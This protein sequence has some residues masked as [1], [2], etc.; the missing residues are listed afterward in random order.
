MELSPETIVYQAALFVALYFV[1]KKLVFDRFLANLDAR[2]HRTHG[3]LEQATRL[4]EEAARLQADYESQMAEI[5]RRGAAEREEIRK[6]AEEE[7]RELVESARQEAARALT[8]ARAK[9]AAEAEATRAALAG[10][11]SRLAEEILANL[12]GRRS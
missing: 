7:E 9:I 6:Q 2:E 1:L 8:E 3:A 11:T 5:R 12:L 4:R 10:E